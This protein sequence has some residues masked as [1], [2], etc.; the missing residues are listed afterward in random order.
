MRGGSYPGVPRLVNGNTRT[1][2]QL[3]QR[4]NSVLAYSKLSPKPRSSKFKVQTQKLLGEMGRS[5]LLNCSD[6]FMN[7]G[8]AKCIKN[9]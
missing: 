3:S 4:P 6:G 5:T 2:T 9:Y 8:I 7:G 1:G